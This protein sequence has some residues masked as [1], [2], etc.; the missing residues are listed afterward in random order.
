MTE[1]QPALPQTATVSS[2]RVPVAAVQGTLA[3]ELSPRHLPPEPHQSV[4]R[5]AVADVVPI[6]QN[7]R[8][9][10]ETWVHRFVQATVEI[11]GGDRPAS[12][13]V[14]WTSGTVYADL[15]R[16]ALLVARAGGHEPGARRVQPV[17][18]Q[19]Q[20][21]HA[22]FVSPTI[23]ETSARV[24]YGNRCRAIALRF[25]RRDERWVCTAMEFA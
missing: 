18:P 6:D 23:A 16:R 13:L 9:R 19:V 21:V 17:R 4:A 15:R 5:S 8:E 7:L 1:L 12:Q 2:I 25:E 10:L 11:V 24:R 22:S 14:R 20:S 3:L